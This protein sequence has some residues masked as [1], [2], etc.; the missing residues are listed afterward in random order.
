MFEHSIRV[1]RLYKVASKI[2][3]EVSEGKGSIKQLVYEGKHT[4]I[5]ALYA[6]I[7]HTFQRTD[8]IEKLFKKSK[9]LVKEPRFDP[10][11]AKVLVTELLWGKKRLA[12]ESKP[13]KTILAY[14]QILKAHLSDVSYNDDKEVEQVDKPRYVRINTLKISVNEAVEEFRNEGW[15]LKR[16]ADVD[17]YLGFLNAVSSLGPE[18][19]MI[20]LHVPYLLIFPPK[21][22]FHK[23]PAYKNG[24]I[25]LQDKA[26]CLPVHI[27][28]PEPGSV[29][30]DMCAAP[31]MK[32]T[33]CAA[34][35]E[36]K[37][38]I[39]AT[40]IGKKR[41]QTLNKIVESSGATCV[42]MLNV[43]VTTLTAKECPEVE[44]ILVDPSCSGSGITDRIEIGQQEP[45]QHRNRLE[46][47]AAFQITILRHALTRFPNVKRV[48][49]S[50]CSV[51]PEENEDVVRQV[52]ETCTQFKLV[53]AVEL[54][55]NKWENF[56][57]SEFGD[58]G[59]YCLY[60]RPDIDL[61]SGF[62]VAVFERLAE[63]E[64][65][66]FL[67]YRLL[68]SRRQ[69]R[70]QW[71]ARDVDGGSDYRQNE[72]GEKG[73]NNIK[74]MKSEYDNLDFENT[75]FDNNT[76]SHK[77]GEQDKMQKEEHEKNFYDRE[78]AEE[79]VPKKKKKKFLLSESVELNGASDNNVESKKIEKQK[80]SKTKHVQEEYDG[81]ENGQ[82]EEVQVDVPKKKKKK[83]SKLACSEEENSS[84]SKLD[85]DV[86][87]GDV[88]PINSEDNNIVRKI[89]KKKKHKHQ[90]ESQSE[91]TSNTILQFEKD[92]SE[93]ETKKDKKKKHKNKSELKESYQEEEAMIQREKKKD[94][95]KVKVSEKTISDTD[96]VPEGG[97][98]P[99]KK[100]KKKNC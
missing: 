93:K 96:N 99:V 16:Y 88:D 85:N 92:V 38:K 26:S 53:P 14:E 87:F 47:L 76:R 25:I 44:Y 15:I 23:H 94:K 49:Y 57:S 37:G 24:S 98:H 69:N 36:D 78:N 48:V 41:F 22:E 1:P 32:T 7:V 27:L 46:K 100:N 12:G 59:R 64:T 65:N 58:I 75:N 66:P 28:N 81:Q 52:L 82:E 51:Y 10:W 60:A 97:L 56:G 30:L 70:K 62:F 90:D 40:E 55:K 61:T 19:F 35:I 18:E 43:D 71:P 39:Y 74:E 11:L 79:Y 63:G 4:N 34:I 42:D 31:G 5:K 17:D 77:S 86:N 83:K 33:Q 91:E 45:D 9:L 6:L 21:T 67:N 95:H 3:K 50:T 89:K 73:K 54:V 2:A 13:V 84:Q 29:L 8:H 72:Q 68:S 20:D 80:R